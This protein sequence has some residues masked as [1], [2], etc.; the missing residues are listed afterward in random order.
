MM[1]RWYDGMMAMVM[2]FL[3]LTTTT[4]IRQICSQTKIPI[5]GVD[6]PESP[7]INIRASF[8]R[9]AFCG[10]IM[11]FDKVTAGAKD[12]KGVKGQVG[13]KVGSRMSTVLRCRERLSGLCKKAGMDKKKGILK[14]QGNAQ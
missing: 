11:G 10:V 8:G 7:A 2:A 13:Q 6:R 9:G 3:R 5:L 4:T 12:A 1:G 14:R